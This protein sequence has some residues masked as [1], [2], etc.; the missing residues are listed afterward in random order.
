MKNVI[1]KKVT[2]KH[3]KKN[4]IKVY[5]KLKKLLEKKLQVGITKLRS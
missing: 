4:L 2:Y 1:K 3:L 5:K